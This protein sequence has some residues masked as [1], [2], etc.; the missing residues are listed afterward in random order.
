MSPGN[1][2]AALLVACFAPL[3]SAQTLAPF[4]AGTYTVT[5]L[6]GIAGLP[7]PYGGLVFKAGDPNTILIGGAANTGAGRIY[8]VPVTRGTGGHIVSFGAITA[9]G[10]GVNND[11]G[12][13]Y[14]PGGVLFYSQYPLNNVGQVR[15]GSNVDDRVVPLGA[16]GIAA[17]T[18]ALNFVPPGYNGAGQFKVSSWSGGQFYNVALSADGTGTYNLTSATLVTT[19]PGGPE[20][21]IYVPLGSPL[22][23]TQS[24]LVAEYSA[25]RVATYT[26]D[27]N[28]NPV[29]ASRQDFITGLTGAEGA[30]IDPVTGDFLFSTFG[31]ANRVIQVRGFVP[32]LAPTTTVVTPSANPSTFGQS[33]TFTATV[34]GA[35]ATGTVT[36]QDNGTNI[37]GCVGIALAAG[38]A[39]CT[40][41]TLTVGSHTIVASYS[42]DSA[43]AA[44]SGSVT[45]TVNA[46][47]PTATTNIPTLSEWGMAILVALMAGFGVMG[48]RRAR[49]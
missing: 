4:Y 46:V 40:T 14:G 33:V 18:G 41:S 26:I 42:G 38:R 13:A 32:P 34:T 6:G 10:F 16:L 3:L 36:F 29:V 11:G 17:S 1:F 37:A 45:Q 49:P 7:T 25:G 43:N 20:G 23:P 21:F 48:A 31:G 24:M 47:A 30:A 27:A 19:L 44:S 9:L 2:V 35:S 12:I 22:F 28:G 15:P 39:T 8:S 5:D